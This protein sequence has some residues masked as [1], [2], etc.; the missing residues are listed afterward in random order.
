[1][2]DLFEPCVWVGVIDG[3]Q[4]FITRIDHVRGPYPHIR[5]TVDEHYRGQ[6]GTSTYDLDRFM[7]LFT[8]KDQYGLW[9]W[10]MRHWVKA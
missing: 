3:L 10:A 4:A 5:V 7:E 2:I 8:K 9:T 6:R 1:M